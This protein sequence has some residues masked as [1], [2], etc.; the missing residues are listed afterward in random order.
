MADDTE[1][2]RAIEATENYFS[3][4]SKTHNTQG[5]TK[6]ESHYP[7]LTVLLNAIGKD[8][9]VVC[10]SQLRDQGAD[11]PDFGLYAAEQADRSPPV[12]G[13]AEP[14]KHGVVEAKGVEANLVGLEKSDQVKKYLRVYELV[15][16][17]NYREFC[18]FRKVG[19]GGG[20]SR[21][22]D[23]SQQRSR[24]LG[25][26]CHSEVEANCCTRAR[27]PSLGISEAVDELHIVNFGTEARRVS[28]CVLCARGI[29]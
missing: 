6:E 1:I 11:H 21:G 13:Q 10:V 3:E 18:L 14:P 8:L 17:T 28:S 9:S 12:V 24:L 2:K 19:G 4:M 22:T 7:A 29:G 15:T 25:N 5:G 16:T 26:D 20:A 23:Y 27:P